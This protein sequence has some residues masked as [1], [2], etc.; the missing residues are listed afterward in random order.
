MGQVSYLGYCGSLGHSDVPYFVGDRV[1]SPAEYAHH[2]S[3]KLVLLPSTYQVRPA[4]TGCP[5]AVSV[6]P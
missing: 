3:E 2:Y 1:A 4:A 6:P 5:L